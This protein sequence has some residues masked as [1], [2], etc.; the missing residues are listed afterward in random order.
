[1]ARGEVVSGSAWGPP[2]VEDTSEKVH[3]ASIGT[4]TLWQM[5]KGVESIT[6]VTVALSRRPRFTELGEETVESCSVK[7]IRAPGPQTGDCCLWCCRGS[8]SY[9]RGQFC[10]MDKAD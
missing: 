5:A 8:V 4:T 10:H 7:Q 3:S 2:S 6:D 1:M 9:T